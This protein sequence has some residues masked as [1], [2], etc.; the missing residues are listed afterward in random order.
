MYCTHTPQGT[1]RAYSLSKLKWRE[2]LA[3]SAMAGGPAGP[4]LRTVIPAFHPKLVVLV[5]ALGV[6]LTDPQ[7]VISSSK[8]EAES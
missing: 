7:A 4:L 5:V 6:F 1:L 2:G 3:L 8:Q